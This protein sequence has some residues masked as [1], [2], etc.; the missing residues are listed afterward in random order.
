MRE[1]VGGTGLGLYIVRGLVESMGGRVWIEPAS[2]GAR[3]TTVVIELPAVSAAEQN[4]A[5]S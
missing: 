3:G 1:G 2:V 4:T 5:A